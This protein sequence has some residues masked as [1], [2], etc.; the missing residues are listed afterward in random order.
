MQSLHFS[1]A[2]GFLGSLVTGAQQY[3]LVTNY[4]PHH[5]IASGHPHLLLSKDV[6]KQDIPD[7]QFLPAPRQ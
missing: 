4:R 2:P 7:F 3:Q 1:M 6:G 5:S